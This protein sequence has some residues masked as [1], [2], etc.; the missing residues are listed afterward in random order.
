[1]PET[2]LPEESAG[3]PPVDDPAAVPATDAADAA[4][5]T[6]GTHKDGKRAL[7]AAG[8]TAAVIGGAAVAVGV[9]RN[10][11]QDAWSKLQ[12]DALGGAGELREAGSLERT[13]P[14]ITVP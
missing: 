10:R 3:S 14:E 7:A 11:E 6:N 4:P 2:L 13:S 1:M 9:A 5:E 8:V 12:A